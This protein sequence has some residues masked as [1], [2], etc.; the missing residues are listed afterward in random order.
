MDIYVISLAKNNNRR[1]Q[2]SSQLNKLDVKWSFFDAIDLRNADV[3]PDEYY[4]YDSSL[5]KPNRPYTRGEVG[6]AMSHINL[7]KELANRNE[8]HAVILEDDAYIRPDF[9]T[10]LIDA[11]AN[12]L[13][14]YDV[15]I[16][17]YSKVDKDYEKKIY[18][19]QPIN[20]KFESGNI[21]IGNT[22]K[23][24][25]CGAVGYI[26][27]KK[28]IDSLAQ[29][30]KVNVLADD[31]KWLSK[32]FGLKIGHIRPLLILEDYHNYVS[33][34][35]EERSPFLISPKRWLDGARYL[36]GYFRKLIFLLKK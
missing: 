32:H 26:L 1:P 29:Q 7:Y 5:Y 18:C 9:K 21:S 31:W 22:C 36:R 8:N 16:L 3:I 13:W 35:E 34:I 20:K 24:W 30:E 25:T 28:A 2:I 4:S 10:F 6:C 19:W 33:S 23:E 17:G 11:K 27:N 12:N 14:E 15:I